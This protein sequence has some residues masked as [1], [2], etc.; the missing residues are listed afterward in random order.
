[1]SHQSRHG[2]PTSSSSPR[3]SYQHHRRESDRYS[4]SFPSSMHSSSRRKSRSPD[5]YYYEDRG[6][7]GSHHHR[8]HRYDEQ[9]QQDRRHRYHSRRRE[10][11]DKPSAPNINVVLRGL[12][13]RMEEEE[14]QSTLEKMQASVDEVSLIRDRDTGRSRR[15]AFVRF[16]SVGHA[17][18]FVEKHFPGFDMGDYFV[19]VDFCNKD[20]SREDKMEWRCPKCGKFNNESRR[21]CVECRQP[22]EGSKAEKRSKE[23][24][25]IEIND[26]S[27]DVSSVA[28]PMLLLRN[29]DN[30]SSEESI[31]KA[32][33]HCDGVRR[34]LLIKDK[35]TK[36]SCSFAFVEFDSRDL[37]AYAF[38]IV[39]RTLKV[40]NTTVDVSYANPG[41]FLPVY[42]ASEWAV[43]ADTPEGFVVYRDD[44]A[45][46]SEFSPRLEAERRRLQEQE[47]K[48]I[49]QEKR[50][51]EEEEKKK[52]QQQKKAQNGDEEHDPLEDDLSA[53]YADMGDI[54]SDNNHPNS[55][56][57]IFSVPKK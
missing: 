49:Q 52:Q 40:D 9:H 16:L 48:R 51:R 44:Q 19:R 10:D 23:A 50:Q 20:N 11:N 12:P 2:S 7:G 4:S 35:L 34:I 54:L 17:I 41:A 55:Q 27:A 21:T 39:G 3:S 53:F 46:A 8:H 25:S 43:S 32:V 13:D 15:F 14:I 47:A 31:Y 45:F 26:G 29:L 18:Q 1:M 38:Q 6:G 36:M 30:L 56:T 57:D 33:E 24:E 37:A 22:V 28:T 42:G 5:R